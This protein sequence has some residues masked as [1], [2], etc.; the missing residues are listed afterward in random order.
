MNK[1]DEV[2]RNRLIKKMRSNAIAIKTNQVEIHF[3]CMKMIWLLNKIQNSTKLNQID[4]NV[5]SRYYSEFSFYPMGAVRIKYNKE[6]LAKLDSELSLIDE[7][8]KV[9]I[10]LKCGE[11]IEKIVLNKQ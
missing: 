10:Y 1:F 3:G 9:Q 4:L 6:Y 2:K 5:F 8:Y 7:K 11:I